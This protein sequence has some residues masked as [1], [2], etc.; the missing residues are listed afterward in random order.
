MV[1]EALYNDDF[2]KQFKTGDVILPKI[3]TIG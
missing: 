2:L 1:R 3:R